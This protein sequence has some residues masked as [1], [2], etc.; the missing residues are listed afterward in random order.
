M[1]RVVALSA[2]VFAILQPAWA[3]AWEQIDLRAPG[4]LE[5]LLRSNPVHYAKVTEVIELAQ[6]FPEAG[7]AR[8][9]PA[10]INASEVQHTRGL[11]KTSYPPKET[12]RF[13][14]DEV[15]YTL[16]VTRHDIAGSVMPVPR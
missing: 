4:A 11:L 12:L 3:G 10:T 8:W 16:D 5:A 14:L 13:M 9:L 7:P 6:Q 15:R 1:T 2:L